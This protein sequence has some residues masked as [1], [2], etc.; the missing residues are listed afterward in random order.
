MKTRK[1]RPPFL[2]GLADLAGIGLATFEK[3]EVAQ[4]G[5][6]RG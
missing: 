1:K 2:A 6:T 4:Y 3:V 5:K